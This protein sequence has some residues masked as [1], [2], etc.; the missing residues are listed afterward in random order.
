MLTPKIHVLV[1][2]NERRPDDPLPCCAHRGGWEVYQA[3]RD[4]VAR[5]GLNRE[6]WVTRTGCM[7][8]CTKGPTVV[9]YPDDVWYGSVSPADVPDLVREHLLGGRPLERLRLK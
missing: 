3:L 8:H 5:A 9:V 7:V 4:A 6:V 2:V 1:C